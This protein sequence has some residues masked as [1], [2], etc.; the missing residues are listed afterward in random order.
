LVIPG[1]VV[2]GALGG[3]GWKWVGMGIGWGEV[4]GVR[5][6]RCRSD[7][8]ELVVGKDWS[9]EGGGCGAGWRGGWAVGGMGG[10]GGGGWEGGVGGA[11][12]RWGVGRVV[13]WGKVGRGT[14]G[15]GAGWQGS[16]CCLGAAGALGAGR[17]GEVEGAVLEVWGRCMCF[18]A[19]TVD[20]GVS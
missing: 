13:V 1:R 10:E 2:E 9:E 20:F 14:V 16:L 8:R 19:L 3:K 12:G 15:G 7:G 6:V 4:R 18:G 11:L 17:G 5:G